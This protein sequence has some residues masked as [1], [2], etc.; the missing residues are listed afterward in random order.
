MSGQKLSGVDL[1]RVVLRAALETA[2]KNGGGGRTAKAKSH[3]AA[4][5]VRGG[6]REPMDGT[7]Y[8]ITRD[9]PILGLP[10]WIADRLTIS[11]A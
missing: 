2:C 5:V 10:D 11:R 1:A 3:T 6:G 9:V 4:V 8:V 7:R